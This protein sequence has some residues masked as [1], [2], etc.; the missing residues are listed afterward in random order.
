MRLLK[1]ENEIAFLRASAGITGRAICAVMQNIRPGMNER[2]AQAYL[3]YQITA[4]GGNRSSSLAIFGGGRNTTKVHYTENNQDLKDGD[5]L[6]MDICS[7]YRHYNSDITRTIPVNG[8]FSPEQ[9]HWYNVV[10][11]AQDM[12]LIH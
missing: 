10:L 2:Q 3:D 11:K 9:R 12:W 6:L 8:R 5:L 7:D 4:D 1:S